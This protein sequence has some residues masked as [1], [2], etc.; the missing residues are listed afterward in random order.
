MLLY[1]LAQ[2]MAERPACV[3]VFETSIQS[4][5]KMCKLS[6]SAVLTRCD[7]LLEW[8]AGAGRPGT[9]KASSMTSSGL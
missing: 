9:V 8:P 7:A 6:T 3:L 5:A 1:L 4:F 2:I